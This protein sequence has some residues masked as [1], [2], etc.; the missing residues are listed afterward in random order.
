[1]KKYLSVYCLGTGGQ[2]QGVG[3]ACFYKV[4]LMR[5]NVLLSS[6]LV[7][8]GGRL[9]RVVGRDGNQSMERYKLYRVL[10]NYA[11]ELLS[12]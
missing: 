9:D 1:M 12:F 10:Y 4:G 6:L 11:G 8:R 3:F 2:R 5:T 7:D